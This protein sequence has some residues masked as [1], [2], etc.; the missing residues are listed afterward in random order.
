MTR[1]SAGAAGE[2]RRALVV[3]DDT[4][5]RLVLTH[6]LRRSG[7][8][9][10]EAADVQ[11]ALEVLEA[12]GIDMVLSDYSMPGGTGVDLL[13]AVDAQPR[14]PLF[15]LITGILEHLESGGEGGGVDARLTKPISSRALADCLT[16]LRAGGAAR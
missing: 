9:V 2:G 7:W 11:P 12:G 15:V 13:P 5:S 10:T 8:Q 16:A 14:R 3:D 6:M 4:V 1:P